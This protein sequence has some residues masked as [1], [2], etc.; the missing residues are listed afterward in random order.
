MHV[1]QTPLSEAILRII[2]KSPSYKVAFLVG[3]QCETASIH[4]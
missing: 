4:M 3:S 2:V 1:F